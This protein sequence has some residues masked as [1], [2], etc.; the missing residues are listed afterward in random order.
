MR[1]WLVDT[2]TLALH[3]LVGAIVL[4]AAVVTVEDLLR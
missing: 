4:W 2:L 3:L 1:N